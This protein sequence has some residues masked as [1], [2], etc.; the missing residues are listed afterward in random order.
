MLLPGRISRRLPL[1]RIYELAEP[2]RLKVSGASTF[3]LGHKTETHQSTRKSLVWR[4]LGN[5][6]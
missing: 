2:L 6:P 3:L 5:L 1:V 4:L